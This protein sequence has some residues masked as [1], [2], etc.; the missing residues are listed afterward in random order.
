WVL[1]AQN[2]TQQKKNIA[3]LFDASIMSNETDVTL[4]KLQEMQS[5]NGG[6]VW[7]KGGLDDR[8]MTQS[9]LTG[10][11]HLKKLNA[12][13]NVNSKQSQAIKVIV[14][15]AISYLDNKIKE[16]YNHLVKMK[17]KLDNNNL[18]YL[19]IHYLYMRSFFTEY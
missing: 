5:A 7:L 3:L 9:I 13:S 10:I 8:Y 19:A 12:L 17:V 18:G 14:D 11:G 2:D 4:A 15:K 16:D 6:F 1:N